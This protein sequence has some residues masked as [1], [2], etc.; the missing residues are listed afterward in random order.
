MRFFRVFLRSSAVDF[1]VG[2]FFS[3]FAPLREGFAVAVA[4]LSASAPLR[5]VLAV[6][7][8]IRVHRRFHLFVRGHSPPLAA[9]SFII[10][11]DR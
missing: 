2:S 5:E 10:T 9:R 3:N 7:S 11:G 1:L 6:S 8:F 4:V